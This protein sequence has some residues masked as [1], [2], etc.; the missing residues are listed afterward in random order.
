MTF[1]P[2][3]SEINPVESVHQERRGEQHVHGVNIVFGKPI[4]L[5]QAGP[6]SVEGQS[7]GMAPRLPADLFLMGP[8]ASRATT[9]VRRLFLI[10]YPQDLVIP[11]LPQ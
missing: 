5:L 9:A 2:P 8:P 10:D 6:K 7:V 4:G 1:R 3:G 11:R